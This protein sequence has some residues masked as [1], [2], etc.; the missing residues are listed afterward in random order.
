MSAC[1]NWKWRA[2]IPFLAKEQTST[3]PVSPHKLH[4]DQKTHQRRNSTEQGPKP[5]P[6]TS[7]HQKQP[8][9]RRRRSVGPLGGRPTYLV[10][11]PAHGPHRL[12]ASMWHLL[13]GSQWQFKRF[14]AHFPAEQRVAPLYKYEGRGS[15]S[16]CGVWRMRELLSQDVVYLHL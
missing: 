7:R 2:I 4:M 8:N 3:N 10:S 6:S 15:I 9:W 13:I 11:R 5:R 1:F 14:H 12:Q 16:R